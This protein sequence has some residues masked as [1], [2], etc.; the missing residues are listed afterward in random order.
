MSKMTGEK[1]NVMLKD[2]MELREDNP[3]LSIQK[4]AKLL[5]KKSHNPLTK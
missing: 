2:M 4:L 3:G 5:K 1:S